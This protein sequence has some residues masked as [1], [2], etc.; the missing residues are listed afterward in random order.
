LVIVQLLPSACVGLISHLINATFI[1]AV[2]VRR[3]IANVSCFDVYL[4]KDNKNDDKVNC[5]K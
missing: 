5:K 4:L 3:V 2:Q 1:G